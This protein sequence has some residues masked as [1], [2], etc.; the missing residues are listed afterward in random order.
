MAFIGRI[1]E[2]LSGASSSGCALA[3][4]VVVLVVLVCWACC[5]NVLVWGKGQRS[6]SAPCGATLSKL[7]L[8]MHCDRANAHRCTDLRLVIQPTNG[9]MFFL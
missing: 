8:G 7:T 5:F 2:S 1:P 6:S 4:L 9:G 3:K